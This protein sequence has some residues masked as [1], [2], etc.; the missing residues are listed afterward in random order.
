MPRRAPAAGSAHPTR[1]EEGHGRGH[2]ARMLPSG[3][4]WK[5]VAFSP[6]SSITGTTKPNTVATTRTDVASADTSV[7]L[8]SNNSNAAS[9]SR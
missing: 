9:G 1:N 5:T 3:A 8:T 6:D 2:F 4:P 7:A